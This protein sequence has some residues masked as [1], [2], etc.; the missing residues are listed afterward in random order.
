[1]I[2]IMAETSILFAITIVSNAVD[3]PWC[4]RIWW[5]K[6]NKMIRKKIEG[7][8][9][10]VGS[11]IK[12]LESIS[13]YSHRQIDR[14]TEGIH[15]TWVRR[16][17]ARKTKPNYLRAEFS[18]T[19]PAQPAPGPSYALKEAPVRRGSFS[20]SCSGNKQKFQRSV[21]RQSWPEA[22]PRGSK[23]TMGEDR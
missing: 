14:Q 11:R 10:N 15:A 16:H 21:V 8:A 17:W 12:S 4:V 13:Y 3:N 5:I 19:E 20:Q 6:S 7:R 2:F 22:N 9:I 23:R 18:S 1:M